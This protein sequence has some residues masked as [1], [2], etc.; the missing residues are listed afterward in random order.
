MKPTLILLCS[1][2][3]IEL[4]IGQETLHRKHNI[5]FEVLE[6]GCQA[7]G[8]IEM[9][10]LDG[11]EFTLHLNNK[12]HIVKPTSNYTLDSTSVK[13]GSIV[14]ALN[15]T[16]SF[17]FE[18]TDC[19]NGNELFK[20]EGKKY[21]LTN[22]LFRK[23]LYDMLPKVIEIFEQH[24]I[25]SK[26][27]TEELFFEVLLPRNAKLIKAK[28]NI[29][30]GV[31]LNEDLNTIT[32][33]GNLQSGEQFDYDILFELTK[34]RK[35]IIPLQFKLP[36]TSIK[37]W[38]SVKEDKDIIDLYINDIR[39]LT[40]YTAANEVVTIPLPV[41]VIKTIKIV[42]VSEGKVPPNTILLEV[43]DGETHHEMNVITDTKT[44]TELVIE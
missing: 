39:V 1:F 8:R 36:V 37:L 40:H 28:S 27:V 4:S 25:E 18:I 26:K 13:P 42:N 15:D 35:K 10:N 38:D 22:K 29:K 43:S 20:V 16:L 14:Y 2:F 6:T 12:N 24:K 23:E 19:D 5:Y 17:D 3:I 41:E 33:K 30:K 31:S 9:I 44:Y 11:T 32:F 34:V 7:K 21:E